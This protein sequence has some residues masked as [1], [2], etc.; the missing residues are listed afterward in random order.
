MDYEEN[1]KTKTTHTPGPWCIDIDEMIKSPVCKTGVSVWTSRDG[2]AICGY[3]VTKVPHT[4]DGTGAD[5]TI[6]NARLIASAPDLLAALKAMRYK[7]TLAQE[8]RPVDADAMADAAIAR[9]EG[10]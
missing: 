10:K 8:M 2:S 4:V 1:M 6:A 9:A 3:K 5:R 7:G